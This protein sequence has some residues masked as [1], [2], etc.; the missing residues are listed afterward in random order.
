MTT[1]YGMAVIYLCLVHSTSAATLVSDPTRPVTYSNNS[2]A[3]PAY[4]ARDYTLQAI[5]KRGDT[6][7]AVINGKLYKTGDYLTANDKL[8]KIDAD[9]VV[10]ERF[11]SERVISLLQ[12]S[13]RQDKSNPL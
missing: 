6:H 1:R 4:V 10:Y 7:Y 8:L 5:Q 11:G 2:D 12:H 13:V 9:K 3:T